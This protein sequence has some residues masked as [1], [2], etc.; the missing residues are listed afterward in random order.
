[1]AS[2]AVDRAQDR[3]LAAT[4]EAHRLRERLA[5]ARL[6]LGTRR[7]L[8]RLH[9]D[10]AQQPADYARELYER[11]TQLRTLIHEAQYTTAIENAVV[12]A[13]DQ[14][15]LVTKHLRT[16]SLA[17]RNSADPLSSRQTEI[18][19]LLKRKDDLSFRLLAARKD[20]RGASLE[21]SQLRRRLHALNRENAASAAFLE[22]RRQVPLLSSTEAQEL[23]A[24]LN[25]ALQAYH[26]SLSDTLVV[27]SA[28]LV[29]LNHLFQK[30]VAELALPLHLYLPPPRDT[31]PPSSSA[32]VSVNGVESTEGGSANGTTLAAEAGTGQAADK[33]V[34]T[35]QRLLKL[36]LLAGRSVDEEFDREADSSLEAV[37]DQTDL[38]KDKDREEEAPH[39]DWPENVELEMAE[40]ERIRTE[41]D[42]WLVA[43]RRV[44][45]PAVPA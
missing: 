16:T 31:S 37:V 41:R 7:H 22:K 14:Q 4:A 32:P 17:R 23:V 6:D 18:A 5:D 44:N 13:I 42:P 2:E 25:P 45:Q 35:P 12:Q 21:R 36:V 19:D 34:L 24:G 28:K 9:G 1:M 26:A 29:R 3:L 27:T 33:D 39:F 8:A 15:V 40:W 11:A 20:L 43:R 38:D 10:R 30:L